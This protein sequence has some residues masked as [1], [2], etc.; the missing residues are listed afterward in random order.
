MLNKN[1]VSP[2][3]SFS[4]KPTEGGQV[5]SPYTHVKNIRKILAI[6]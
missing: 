4:G 2:G 1:H 3:F 6:L 5:F